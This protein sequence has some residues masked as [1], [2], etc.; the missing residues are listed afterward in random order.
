MHLGLGPMNLDH[1]RYM[2][3][4][5]GPGSNIFGPVRMNLGLSGR[6][7]AAF[8]ALSRCC[9]QSE[10]DFE[11]LR[12]GNQ[13]CAEHDQSAGPGS[14]ELGISVAS[15]N[16]TADGG[17]SSDAGPCSTPNLGWLRCAVCFAIPPNKGSSSATHQPSQHKQLCNTRSHRPPDTP[18]LQRAGCANLPVPD[19]RDCAEGPGADVLAE[20]V[21]LRDANQGSPRAVR[22]GHASPGGL[23]LLMVMVW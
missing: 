7:R 15:T 18:N 6:V 2:W 17:G 3:G 19:Q 8:D 1:T 11:Q 10:V 21:H 16:L 22:W 4:L 5:L 13:T 14:A 12:C 20:L 23:L 9:D